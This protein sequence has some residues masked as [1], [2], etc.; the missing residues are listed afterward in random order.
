A[1]PFGGGVSISSDSGRTWEF[2][3]MSLTSIS[4]IV[5]SKAGKVFILSGTRIYSAIPKSNIWTEDDSGI[6]YWVN[7]IQALTV[8]NL[9]VVV[10]VT[11]MGIFAYASSEAAWKS[12]TPNVS[13]ATIT[14]A[15]YAPNGKLYA[16][17]ASD[18]VFSLRDSSSAWLQCGIVPASV[19][20]TGFDGSGTLFAGT[21]DGVFEQ[22]PEGWSRVSDGLSRSTVYQLYFS[23]MSNRFYTSTK[24][25]LFYLPDSGNYW[26]PLVKQWAYDFVESP[27]GEKYSGTPG[28]ILKALSG[29]DV[30]D[31]VQTI[32]IPI[33]SIYCLAVDSSNN[34]FAGTSYDGIFISTDGGSFWTQGG[35][36][37]PLIFCSVKAMKIDHNGRIF[38]G[39][40]TSGA[41]YS[42]DHGANWNSIPSISGKNVTCFFVN[43]SSMYFA[44]TSDCGAFISTD[45]GI[46]WHSANSGL[47][48]SSII[49]INVDR[50][51]HLYAGTENGLFKSTGI[52]TGVARKNE[53]P[54][55]FTL[56]Q[57]YP[58]P[59]NPTTMI[60][61]QL[62][63][64]S[65]VT[66]K[67]YDVLGR[68]VKTL[69]EGRQT[70]GEHSVTFDASTLASG[71]YFYRLT[72]GGFG[73]T[74]RMAL[75]K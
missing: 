41:Y 61:Y 9:G 17:T 67:V 35:V 4:S 16:G 52:V 74:K 71:T 55:S 26:I 56:F 59:F 73:E 43:D 40:D 44:G 15:F 2:Y 20:S 46:S 7:S 6:P 48:D 72:A 8:D 51:G 70:S 42:D 45:R 14:S 57:N 21:G 27:N 50:Q 64:N 63:V 11:D 49:S 54:S 25:G 69:Q 47:T 34:L 32:G 60:S 24:G 58:N 29:E 68:L 13:L 65:V 5:A 31:I 37:S 3:G 1:P 62:A 12:I 22:R 19:T 53:V 18:G 39:T 36:S 28:G 10:A 33:T 66:L 30:W 38:A 75:I 23:T